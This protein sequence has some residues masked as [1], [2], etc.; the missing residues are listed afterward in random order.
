MREA[1]KQLQQ[2][3]E[4]NGFH[5]SVAFNLAFWGLQVIFYAVIVISLV[6]HFGAW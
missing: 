3:F 5:G 4:A 6:L 2:W 1:E